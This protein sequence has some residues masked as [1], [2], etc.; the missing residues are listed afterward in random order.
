MVK[1]EINKYPHTTNALIDIMK[2]L[3]FFTQIPY[4]EVH[5]LCS[6]CKTDIRTFSLMFGDECKTCNGEGS[7][8]VTI[9]DNGGNPDPAM[10]R[11]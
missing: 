10:P 6:I 9:E 11:V 7:F 3:D 5:L 1:E 8:P 4:Y 2:K